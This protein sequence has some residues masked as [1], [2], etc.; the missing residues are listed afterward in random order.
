MR[1]GEWRSGEWGG[2]REMEDNSG[3]KGALVNVGVYS[4][5]EIQQ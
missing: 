3:R 4:M 5:T 1:V 2:G